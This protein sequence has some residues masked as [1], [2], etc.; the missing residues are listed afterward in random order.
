MKKYVSRTVLC[1]ALA[2]MI[3]LLNVCGSHSVS[4]HTAT[5]SY[6]S[7]QLN[8]ILP[9]GIQR[10]QE[11]VLN[12]HGARLNDVEEVLFY[13]PPGFEVTNLEVVSAT[14]VKVTLNIADDCRLGEHTVQLRARSGI[15]EFRTFQVEAYPEV[16]EAEPNGSF[17]E[18]QAMTYNSIM[19]GIVQSEDVD[20]F[21]VDAK[22]GDRISAEVFAVRLG[23]TL[24]DPYVAILDSK[25]FELSSDDDTPLARQDAVASIVAPE[26][27]KYYIEVRESSYGGNGNCRYR[28]HVGTFPRPTAI[29]PAGGKVGETVEVTFFGDPAGE[30]TSSVT[31]PTDIRP[32]YGIFPED[33]GGIAP[34]SL[35]FRQYEFGNV[36]EQE[37][38]NSF[39]E[40]S[41]AELPN[42]FNGRI[43]EPGDIDCFRFTAKKGEAYDLECFAR[44]IR[45]GLDPVINVY[46]G[47]GRGIAGNDD[48]RGPDSYL[49]F[50]VPEDGEYLVRVRD[51]LGRG[52]EDFVYR[53]EFHA[54]KPAL[55]LS[56][57]RVARYSQY[58]QSIFIARGNRFATLIDASRANFGG[59]IV[60]D[61]SQLPEG[62]TMVAP[63]MRSNLNRMPVV[64]EAAADAPVGGK[65]VDFRGR[66]VDE[67]TGIEGGYRNSADLVRG[68]PNNAVYYPLVV[69]Q[70]A[71]AVV[72]E[73]PF[74]LEIVQPQ[75]PLVRN[76]TKQ[77]KI[78]AHRAEGFN[79]QI[80]IQF[81]FR[82]PGVGAGSSIN[83][84]ADKS[85]IVYTLNANANAQVGDWPVY[86]IGSAN[87]GG[88]AW[89]ASQM[90]TLTV[91]EPYATFEVSRSSC[92]Q[93]QLAQMLCK[94][95]QLHE[96]EGEATA[97]LLGIPAHV[98]A[99]PLKFTKDAEEL[100]FQVQT[101]ENSPVGKHR[102]VFVQLEVPINGE[103]VVARAGGN[104][105]QIDKP[106]PVEEPAAEPAA[107]ATQ[108]QPM[109]EQKPAEPP[110]KP[111]TRLEK[112]RLEAQKRRE[113]EANGQQE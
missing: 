53:L 18:A 39:G 12:F 85:E 102:N 74:K 101:A 63:P 31:V 78:V 13:D 59:E 30:F 57:P 69:G 49:R 11:R 21:V 65:L 104:E 54:V 23:D 91:A 86:V 9:R 75:S 38:N 107:P 17:E 76:G 24:F 26:D 109:P 110:A 48:S 90:A 61:D 105:L 58:R 37:P 99:E 112:L 3:C 84:P 1:S 25:R 83:I 45:S 68:P 51:H 93:G 106:I 64:F 2:S 111:L 16:A 47:D 52:Q 32:N 36:L 70:I 8:I 40:A 27:G 43:S 113:Q 33:Q 62:V 20:Y 82:P 28:L 15:S 29:Y 4:A 89:V 41:P 71:F 67:A 7:P 95:S 55:T 79:E 50:N 88:A 92:E 96:F 94:I 5:S 80:N 60:L 56:I 98:T 44:R 97:R 34:S 108:A 103:T 73:L 35:P 87:V 81:P 19:S 22:Q 10:G 66:H 46:H 72:D 77:L 42:A 6:S 100:I 14:H